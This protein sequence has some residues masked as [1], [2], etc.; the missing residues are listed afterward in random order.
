MG[1]DWVM[2]QGKERGEVMIWAEALFV[3]SLDLIR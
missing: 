2:V 3:F 1:Q